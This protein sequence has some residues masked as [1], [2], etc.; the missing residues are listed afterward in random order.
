MIMLQNYTKDGTNENP[1][2][3]AIV[4]DTNTLAALS[5]ALIHV[6]RGDLSVITNDLAY[7]ETLVPKGEVERA[8]ARCV[9]IA[10][11][12]GKLSVLHNGT[13]SHTCDLDVLV[14][15]ALGRVT[16][17]SERSEHVV[18]C[19]PQQMKFV[20]ATVGALIASGSESSA[21]RPAMEVRGSGCR[22]FI[23]SPSRSEGVGIYSTLW[24][25][26]MRACGERSIVDAALCDL[27]LQA[28]RWRCE[29]S[30]GDGRTEVCFDWSG[31][32]SE[33]VDR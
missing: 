32:Q 33:V 19:D 20:F 17:D 16:L 4:T 22:M 6:L 29:V 31:V 9:N 2:E 8:K 13:Q 5:R 28:H 14:Q 27:I 11:F 18:H 23:A 26:A 3:K 30:V 1:K 12:V 25:F 10:Q 15:S 24:E 7:L 21:D